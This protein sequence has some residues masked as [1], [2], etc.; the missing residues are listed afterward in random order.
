MRFSDAQTIERL[1][2]FWAVDDEKKVEP[3]LSW[4]MEY[5]DGQTWQ[6]FEKYITDVFGLQP[7]RYNTIHPSAELSCHG[8]RLIMTCRDERELGLLDIDLTIK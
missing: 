3:P 6:V 2:V 4:K 8:L 7:D 5:H 1:G